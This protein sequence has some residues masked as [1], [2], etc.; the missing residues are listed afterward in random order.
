[1]ATNDYRFQAE[2]HE[3]H[4]DQDRDIRLRGHL[5][6]VA[7]TSPGDLGLRALIQRLDE[8]I[9]ARARTLATLASGG[10]FYAA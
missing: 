4:E 6:S 8:A 9:D 2:M 10:R 3:L 5:R 7:A 1:M